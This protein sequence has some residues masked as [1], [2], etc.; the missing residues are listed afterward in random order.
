MKKKV[1]LIDYMFIMLGVFSTIQLLSIAGLTVFNIC[2]VLTVTTI[3]MLS[4]IS[5][6]YFFIF[7]FCTTVITVIYSFCVADLTKG[8][9]KSA[10]IG[11]I[12][13]IFILITYIVM[14]SDVLRAINLVKGFQISC[15]LTLVW[16]VLQ[17]ISSYIFRIDLN[18]LVFEKIF[19]IKDAMGDYNTETGQ[20]IPSG[21]FS[22]RAILSPI[23]IYLFFLSDNLFVE[24][25]I[26]GI[27]LLTKSTALILGCALGV[28]FR[29]LSF[30]M[31]KHDIK[32]KKTKIIS[33]IILTIILVSICL[34]MSGEIQNIFNYIVQRI[35]DSRSNKADNSSVVHYLYYKNL[36]YIIK[37][38]NLIEI[39][40]GNGFATSGLFY[41]RFNG[42]YSWMDSWVVESDYINIIISQGIL[43]LVLWI[44]MMIDIIRKSLKIKEFKTV[45][46]VL[47]IMF[48]GIMYNIQFNWFIV[49][50]F[51]FWVLVKNGINIFTLRKK[52]KKIND[53][54]NNAQK[55]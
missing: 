39:L 15:G 19:M 10:L 30:I 26:I 41:T 4:R 9:L 47:L 25:L 12:I 1:P 16:C 49:V 50:E 32:S 13:Y 43:G 20:L 11:G 40:F 14:K 23:F 18:T 8:F 53:L 22:H 24:A 35:V 45:F 34:Y 36:F 42:Q 37:D 44:Y 48:I 33:G 29:I 6:D 17:I 52:E 46:F 28:F 7:S 27:S 2:L 54:Y 31:K 3:F 38:F 51:A 5:V 55:I 21:F